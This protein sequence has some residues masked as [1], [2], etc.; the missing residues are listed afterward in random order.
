MTNAFYL[1]DINFV[2]WWQLWYE[3]GAW[4]WC[5]TSFRGAGRSI[6]SLSH[7]NILSLVVGMLGLK[8]T[9]HINCFPSSKRI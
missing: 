3:Q 7:T 2:P 1:E 9:I 8:N 6:I 4:I 5:L